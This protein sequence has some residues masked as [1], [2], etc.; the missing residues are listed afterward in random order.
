[1]WEQLDDYIY[2]IRAMGNSIEFLFGICLFLNG[3]FILFFESGGVIRAIMMIIHFYYNIY[4][5]AKEGKLL[6]R[7]EGVLLI[8]HFPPSRLEIILETS[9]CCSQN[10][11]A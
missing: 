3:L 7:F 8:N 5:Q 2:Y 4:L 1:M 10:Q 6:C 9:S 11:L